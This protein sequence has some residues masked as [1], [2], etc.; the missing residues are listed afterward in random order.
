MQMKLIIL[1]LFAAGLILWIY[2][3]KTVS[4]KPISTGTIHIIVENGAAN[5]EKTTERSAII[6][7]AEVLFFSLQKKYLY[8]PIPF[9]VLGDFYVQK[10]LADKALEKYTQMIRYLNAD[11]SPEKLAD[12]LSFIRSQKAENIAN[13]IVAFYKQAGT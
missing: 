4:S 9:K 12:V 13:T 2:R 6:A 11:L 7:E 8:S 5:K 1:T 10:G 3:K